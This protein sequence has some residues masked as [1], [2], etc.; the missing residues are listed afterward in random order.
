[1]TYTYPGGDDDGGNDERFAQKIANFTAANS[2]SASNFTGPLSFLGSYQYIMG[3]SYLTGLGAVTEM[4]A[5]VSFWNRY[6]RT[7]YSASIGQLAYN[8]SYANGTAR[9]KPVLRTTSQSRIQNSE[10]NWALG[11]FGTSFQETPDATLANFTSDYDVVIIPEGGTE[12]NT[13]AS[14]D[15]C[16]NDNIE[17]I[18]YIGDDD[19]F[20]YTPRYL[21]NATARLQQYVPSDL[22]LTTN[23][24]YAM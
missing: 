13:L 6:G 9:R 19:L 24:T 2:G 22:T 10:I 3:E 8:A 14:Y 16:E 5:G 21:T 7:L 1:M 18:G 11:F 20:T 23:D 17:S 4:A 15:S 12:N